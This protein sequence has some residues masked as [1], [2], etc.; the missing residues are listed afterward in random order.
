VSSAPAS[1]GD[2]VA[3]AATSP[4]NA[5]LIGCPCQGGPAGAVIGRWNGRTW[6]TVP[7]PVATPPSGGTGAAIAA[8]GNVVW[9]AGVYSFANVPML[10]RWTGRAWKLT[11][12]PVKNFFVAGVA[13]TS[14]ANAWAVGTTTSQ[15]TVILHWNG[16]SWH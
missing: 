12:V 4:G 7:T 3:V 10:L 2:P 5:W 9:A 14:A 16:S 8:A 11:S 15:R 6:K 13:V 1:Q